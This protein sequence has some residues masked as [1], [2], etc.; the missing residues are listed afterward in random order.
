[1]MDIQ[2]ITLADSRFPNALKNGLV[3]PI[4]TCLWTIGNLEILDRRLVGFF[5]SMKCSG[6]IILK[7]YD[8]A[9]VWRNAEVPVIGGFQSPMEKE[10]LDLLLRGQQPVVICPARSIQNIRLPS[11]WR[12]AL[13]QKRLLI[14]SA[15]EKRHR[16]ATAELA[17][18]RNRIVASLASEIFVA[19]AGPGTKTEKLCVEFI[20]GHICVHVIDI[21]DN[22]HLIAKGAVPIQL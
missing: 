14:V 9:Q 13:D 18:T 19:H 2:T 3:H 10:C 7:T 8:L 20:E 1:M 15:F 22:A 5:C 11:T 21:P 4:P 17:V 6:N 16:R 12:Q